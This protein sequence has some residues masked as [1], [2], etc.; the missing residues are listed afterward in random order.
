[1]YGVHIHNIIDRFDELI[2]LWKYF[3]SIL[4]IAIFW[5]QWHDSHCIMRQSATPFS[6]HFVFNIWNVSKTIMLPQFYMHI[7]F[8][9][10]ILFPKSLILSIELF[11]KASDVFRLTMPGS[12]IFWHAILTDV[13]TYDCI[14]V[15]I[16]CVSLFWG[17]SPQ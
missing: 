14:F 8:L 16:F 11:S 1:M 2:P 6:S 17:L 9:S 7:Y 4:S 13:N 15:K 12:P 3:A 5:K 10:I